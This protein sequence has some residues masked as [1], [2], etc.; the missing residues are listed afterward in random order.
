VTPER[1]DYLMTTDDVVG[2]TA[3]EMRDGWH[4]C[5]D[6]D[7]LLCQ[8]GAQPVLRECTCAKWTEAEIAEGE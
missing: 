2:L 4:F 7:Y 1:Y 5:P 6:F 8:F 3:S